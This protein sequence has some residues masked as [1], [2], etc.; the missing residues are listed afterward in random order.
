MCGPVVYFSRA[1]VRAEGKKTRAEVEAE[2]ELK[3]IP[4][5]AIS[6]PSAYRDAIAIKMMWAERGG[7]IRS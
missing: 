5:G 6:L 1:R 7:A 3:F 4:G 2:E